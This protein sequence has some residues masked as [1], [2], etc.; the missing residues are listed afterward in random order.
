[1]SGKAKTSRIGLV[2]A[3][4]VAALALFAGTGLSL[5]GDVPSE[6]QLLNALKPKKLTRSMSVSPADAAKTAEEQKFVDT[7]RT[8]RRTRSLSSG[9]REKV[10]EIAKDKPNVDIDI[11]FAYNSADLSPEA[12][13][14]VDN[15][16]RVMSELKD[17][18]FLLGGHTDAKGG[19]DYNQGLSERR[20]ETVK[21]YLI[22]KYKL[23]AENLLTAGY[24]KSQPK[25]K[26]NPMADANRR[27]QVVNM[28]SQ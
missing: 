9:E 14:A 8:T 19:E 4:I 11:Q 27:V 15:L 12:R 7:L 23:P 1:M 20:A 26:D 21:R 10:S 16:G 2:C 18:V 13:P 22:E 28:N 24:G 25:I 6:E 3:S 5:A 17:S